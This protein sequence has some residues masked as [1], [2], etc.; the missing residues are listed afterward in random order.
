MRQSEMNKAEGEKQ[1]RILRSEAATQETV[2]KGI[3]AAKAAESEKLQRIL[4][5]EA[6]MQT[7]INMA[8]AEA[9]AA[10]SQKIQKILASEASKQAEINRAQGQAQA[11][12]MEMEAR[13]KALEGLSVSLEKGGAQAAASFITADNYVKAFGNIAKTNNTVII[14]NN[15]TDVGSMVAQAMTIYNNVSSQVAKR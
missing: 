10:E 7:R 3:A 8:K 14:P 2:N 4:Q 1:S 12:Q 5:S 6:E 9:E 13:C 15:P 11:I